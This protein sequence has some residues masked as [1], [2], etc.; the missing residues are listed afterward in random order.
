MTE[1]ICTGCSARYR[2]RPEFAGLRFRCKHCGTR[3]VAPG[4]KPKLSNLPTWM[5]LRDIDP[6][7]VRHALDLIRRQNQPRK[8]TRTKPLTPAELRWQRLIEEM[9]GQATPPP[10]KRPR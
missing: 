5:R 7:M 4:T 9:Y 6:A 3:F 2:V 8:S 10:P 1:V